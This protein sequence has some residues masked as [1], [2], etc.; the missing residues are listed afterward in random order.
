MIEPWKEC[1]LRVEEVKTMIKSYISEGSVIEIQNPV[2]HS[3]NVWGSVFFGPI[4]CLS[5]DLFSRIVVDTIPDINGL[6]EAYESVQSLEKTDNTAL[7][8]Y[9]KVIKN[10]VY[11]NFPYF[12]ISCCNDEAVLFPFY[13]LDML[14]EYI[15]TCQYFDHGKLS[16]GE[17][18]LKVTFLWF[19]KKG[20]ERFTTIKKPTE[21]IP[22]R[23]IYIRYRIW[24]NSNCF[25]KFA[26]TMGERDWFDK[27]G[28]QYTE[29]S[30]LESNKFYTGCVEDINSVL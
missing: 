5:P 14:M 21:N 20:L 19:V 6:K 29:A 2:M 12:E 8:I 18:P 28:K 23:Y 25:S 27:S 30:L 16:S 26:S 22:S 10:R 13:S 11:K 3:N 15:D 24:K 9:H 7:E 17:N 4:K 1:R